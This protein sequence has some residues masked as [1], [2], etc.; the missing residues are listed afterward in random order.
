MQVVDEWILVSEHEIAS[1]VRKMAIFH[2]KIVEGAAG[3]ALAAFLKDRRW[4]DEHPTAPA[5]IVACGA[6][7]AVD[8]L[9]QILSSA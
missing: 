4:R 5:V 3:V 6:N 1:A 2:K 7:I 9:Q 8:V